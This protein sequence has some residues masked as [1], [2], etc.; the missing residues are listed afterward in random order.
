[1]NKN[2]IIDYVLRTPRN[3]NP[4]VLDSMLMSLIAENKIADSV[5]SLSSGL[6]EGKDVILTA[7]VETNA[8]V[9]VNGKASLDL[10]KK[11]IKAQE[12]SLEYYM[13]KAEGEDTVITLSGDGVISA[14][15]SVQAIPVTAANGA[16]VIINGGTYLCK[17]QMQCVYANGGK[18]EI[19]GGTFGAVAGEEVK[20]L[21]NVQNTREITDTQIYG[22][23]FIGRDPALGDDALGG[24]FVAPGYKSVEV[25][26]GIFEVVKE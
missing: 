7:N 23:R 10:N 4:A 9:L 25:E 11:T 26:S 8:P 14:G 2:K 21:L 12:G 24:S 16:K 19:Y 17:G 18:V 1:M 5:E 22:G 15:A 3:T 13:I 20:D 6:S